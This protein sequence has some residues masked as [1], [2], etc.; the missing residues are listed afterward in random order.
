MSIPFCKNKKYRRCHHYLEKNVHEN[1]RLCQ[2]AQCIE[3]NDHFCQA[4]IMTGPLCCP[5]EY[6]RKWFNNPVKCK[7]CMNSERL[8][9]PDLY[10]YR[11]QICGQC[12]Q[13][14]CYDCCKSKRICSTNEYTRCIECLVAESGYLD[15]IFQ[16]LS[17]KLMNN[18]VHV[19]KTIWDHDCN[20]V[21]HISA[22]WRT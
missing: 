16:Q 8:R 14:I 22:T 4:C 2:L 13:F 10:F 11:D 18:P 7:F 12:D 19:L 5:C 21:D 3:C 1:C 15:Q 6:H 20:K 17:A 9:G